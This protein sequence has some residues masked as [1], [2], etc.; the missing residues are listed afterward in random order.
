MTTKNLEPGEAPVRGPL[1]C[2]ELD[3]GRAVPVVQ[4]NQIRILDQAAHNLLAGRLV[5]ADTGL[6]GAY[7]RGWVVG[8]AQR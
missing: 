1:A 3:E 2:K 5:N 7:Q 4:F 6:P 8:P